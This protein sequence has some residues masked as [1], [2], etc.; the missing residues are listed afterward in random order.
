MRK[1]AFLCLVLL[2]A[3][4]ANAQEL[5]VIEF[6]ADLTM[7]DAAKNPKKDANGVN[8]GLIKLGLVV[9]DAEFEGDIISAEYANGE[10]LL[11]M[12]RGANWL[13]IKTQQYLPLRS[14]FDPIQSNVTYVM[15]VELPSGDSTDYFVE[16]ARQAVRENDTEKLIQYIEKVP[17]T[18]VPDDLLAM[19][20]N[21]L[22]IKAQNDLFQS[23]KLKTSNFTVIPDKETFAQCRSFIAKYPKS[24]H[25]EE[26]SNLLRTEGI[27]F[28]QGQNGESQN[29]TKRGSGNTPSVP[30]T[31]T[32]PYKPASTTSSSKKDRYESFLSIGVGAEPFLTRPDS[33]KVTYD[34]SQL[35]GGVEANVAVRIGRPANIVNGILGVGISTGSFVETNLHVSPE[36]R[37]NFDETIYVGIGGEI[38]LLS[39]GNTTS[40]DGTE[41]TKT[42]GS[43]LKIMAGYRE[44]KFDVYLDLRI[45]DETIGGVAAG[46]GF[47]W[48]LF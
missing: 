4:T 39:F 40:N 34:T 18:S 30:S 36:I 19:Y 14:E 12:M 8:C 26:V 6:H 7:T 1:I 16:Q 5:K 32:T 47:R 20:D 23:L 9:P 38:S 24:E 44:K 45:W 22:S 11:Y 27:K 46:A 2:Y 29:S 15:V 43:C 10:W 25:Y 21:A 17:R 35:Y 31:N 41:K 28:L 37:L 3:I 48:Y 33:N 42:S 13:T